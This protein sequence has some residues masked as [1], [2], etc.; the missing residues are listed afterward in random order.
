V[1]RKVVRPAVVVV[2]A[3]MQEQSAKVVMAATVATLA[4]VT[5]PRPEFVVAAEVAAAVDQGGTK[6]TKP[7]ILK[8]VPPI[9][10]ARAVQ[11]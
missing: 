9:S 7:R 8:A 5:L 2:G 6:E 4:A 3:R 10:V 11:G 1:E